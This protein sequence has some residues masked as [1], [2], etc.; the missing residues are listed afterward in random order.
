MSDVYLN[1][2]SVVYILPVVYIGKSSTV[3]A[4]ERRN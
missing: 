1:V 3:E 2:Q 4:V